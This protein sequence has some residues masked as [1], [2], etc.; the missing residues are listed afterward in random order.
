MTF[1]ETLDPT[2]GESARE[3]RRHPE[4]VRP[5]LDPTDPR[6]EGEAGADRHAPER[7]AT[8]GDGSRDAA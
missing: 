8:W 3:A 7:E 5:I 1:E 6:Y 2:A 4:A